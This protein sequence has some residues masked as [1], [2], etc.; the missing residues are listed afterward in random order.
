MKTALR[1]LTIWTMLSCLSTTSAAHSD[2][3]SPRTTY[4]AGYGYVNLPGNSTFGTKEISRN[5]VSFVGT[6]DSAILYSACRHQVVA[7]SIVQAIYGAGHNLPGDTFGWVCKSTGQIDIEGI[8]TPDGRFTNQVSLITQTIASVATKGQP[9]IAGA[10]VC[11]A[12]VGT[13]VYTRAIL[14]DA[15][16]WFLSATQGNTECL[17]ANNPP[18]QFCTCDGTV[19]QAMCSGKQQPGFTDVIQFDGGI[20]S[21]HGF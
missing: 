4:F 20:V 6:F 19:P 5:P 8:F 21:Y 11:K 10:L 14:D 2:C 17:D 16:T 15:Q 1:L 12:L 7:A 18:Y 13:K 3:G 9:T